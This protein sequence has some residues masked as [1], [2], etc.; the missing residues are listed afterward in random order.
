MPDD[1]NPAADSVIP[2]DNLVIPDVDA[3][4]IP[5]ADAPMIPGVDDPIAP[6]TDAPMTLDVDDLMIPGDAAPRSEL[7]RGLWVV[8]WWGILIIQFF[9]SE[10]RN[11]SLLV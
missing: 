7:H 10:I 11:G 8:L 9:S 5:D 4:V 2:D 3:P 1:D 6:D